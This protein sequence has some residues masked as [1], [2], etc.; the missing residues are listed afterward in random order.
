MN[1]QSVIGFALIGVILLLFSW[2][3]TKQLQQQQEIRYIQDSIAAAQAMELAEHLVD[4]VYAGEA[5]PASDAEV[6]FF[7]SDLLNEAFSAENEDR[8]SYLEN[9]L[10]KVGISSKGAQPCEVLIKKYYKY[11]STA[12]V[13]LDATNAFDIELDAG[14]YV[15]TSDFTFRQVS[16]TDESLVYRLY[17]DETSYLEEIYALAPDSYKI[18][19][20]LHFVGMQELI[21]KTSGYFG[22]SWNMNVPRL[23]KGYDNEKNYSTLAYCYEGSQ[24]IKQFQFRKK[25]SDTETLA[26]QT[27][28]VAFKQQFFSSI[29][30]AEDSFDSGTVAASIYPESNPDRYLINADA[31]LHVL[32]GDI[33]P[34]FSKNFS[35]YF[36]PNH[37]PTLKSYGNHFDKLIPMGGWLVGSINKYVIIPLFNWL[38][39]FFSNYGIII[40]MMTLIIK[41][42]ISP[43]T[44]RSYLSSAKMKV[45]K[46]EID[47]INAKYSKESD[48]MKRQQATMDLYKKTG[49]S[50]F[51]GCL[52]ILL[53]FPI[54]YAMFRFFPSSFE[55]RQQGFLWAKDLSGYDSILDFGFN[56]P[57]YGD[58]ISLFALLMGVSMW[59]YSK[60][61]LDTMDTNSQMAGMKFMQLW[62]MPIFM[63]VLC[64]NFSA[65]LSYYYMLSNLFTIAQNVVIRKWFVDEEKLYAQLKSKA[66]S[67]APVKKSK[68]QQRL[69]EAQRIQQEQMK[70]K[71]R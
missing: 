20:T 39:K 68:F 22:V 43:L 52:P 70:Q 71:R 33:T 6:P 2:Y 58:H 47:K 21:P 46:P 31:K 40:L 69:E 63:V 54:L 14:Q 15:N 5:V 10:I 27:S 9:D 35:F 11:D 34:D 37:Y 62:F 60:M 16:A 51:G 59:F 26:G 42:V 30:F 25:T 24:D 3:N 19:F 17:F 56:V 29:L 45:L 64:N 12:L 4:S 44:L 61:T 36:V 28:W 8:V 50:M 18:D 67:N 65:G 7:K 49:V 55:L 23:E 38:S 32:Y 48:A 57:L 53:Q 41:V 13:L 1:K 66:D